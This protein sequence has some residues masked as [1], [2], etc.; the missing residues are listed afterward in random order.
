V[1]STD[2]LV[3]A[4]FFAE[5]NEFGA[6]AKLAPA[7]VPVLLKDCLLSPILFRIAFRSYQ[8][9]SLIEES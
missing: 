3:G 4:G 9:P 2:T 6:D 8:V 5:R 7:G 1:S